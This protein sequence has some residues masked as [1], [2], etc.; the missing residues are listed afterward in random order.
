MVG[1]I[2]FYKSYKT[3]INLVGLIALVGTLTTCVLKRQYNKGVSEGKVAVRVETVNETT[4]EVR[5][6]IKEAV[7]VVTD[8][9]EN[10]VDEIN[11]LRKENIIPEISDPVLKEEYEN[12]ES[13]IS[14]E[15]FIAINKARAETNK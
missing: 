9:F 10:R 15:M 13:G 1:I 2:S 14:E 4:K 8:K 11:R 3:L 7:F 6:N 12:P 5:E